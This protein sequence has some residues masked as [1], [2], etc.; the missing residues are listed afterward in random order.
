MA[1]VAVADTGVYD[2]I[3]TQ[4]TIQE[5]SSLARLTALGVRGVLT[6]QASVTVLGARPTGRPG[7]VTG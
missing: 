5:P 2:C 1:N 4:G 3:V 6:A 7:G